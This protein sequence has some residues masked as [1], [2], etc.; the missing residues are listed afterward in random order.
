MKYFPCFEI[1]PI[2]NSGYIT[3]PH[4]ATHLIY[5]KYSNPN[6]MAHTQTEW[7]T[8]DAMSFNLVQLI[9]PFSL[10]NERALSQMKSI[11]LL[12]PIHLEN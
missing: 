1:Q 8:D 10:I 3:Q 7:M 6:S 5:L 2:N 9:L 12:F 4:A 11:N